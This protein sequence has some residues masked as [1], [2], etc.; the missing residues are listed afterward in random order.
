MNWKDRFT[1]FMSGRYGMDSLSR[2][3]IY[4][5]VIMYIL[6]LFLHSTMLSIL[7]VFLLAFCYYRILSRKVYKRSL[8]NQTYLEHIMHAKMKYENFRRDM[9]TKKTHHIYKCPHCKQKIRVPKG[10]GRISIHCPKCNHEFI[11]KS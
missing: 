11:K 9:N 3:L 2:T 10:K 7:S 8:E 4:F 6:N 1:R 5:I